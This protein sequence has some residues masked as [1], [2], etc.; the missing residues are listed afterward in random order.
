MVTK[1]NH[2]GKR[3]GAG[4]KKQGTTKKVSLTLSDEL[5]AEIEDFDGNYSDYIRSL[6][7][8]LEK[9]NSNKIDLIEVTK[10]KSDE[11]LKK[12]TSTK[13]QENE[14]FTKGYIKSYFNSYIEDFLKEQPEESEHLEQAIIETY[15][16]ILNVM[17]NGEEMAE[18]E[19]SLRYRSPF[20]NKWFSSMNNLLKTEIPRLI[21]SSLFRLKRK[22]ENAK[23]RN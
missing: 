23:S 19:I 1:F 11:I 14:E 15:Q 17:F 8:Q 12:V 21:E 4:R 9:S 3:E 2:G 22:A 16:S 20:S 10:I 7:H 13:H 6:K 5:W 18:I